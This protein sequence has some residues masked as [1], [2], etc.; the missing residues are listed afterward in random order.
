MK[1]EI[2]MEGDNLIA[3]F[4]LATG[5]DQDKDGV[6]SVELKGSAELVI[7][8]SEALDELF[9]STSLL[10]KAKEKIEKLLGKTL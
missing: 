4:E 1:P 8:G 7:D 10:Q 3:K 5:V 2:K 9:K 6:K